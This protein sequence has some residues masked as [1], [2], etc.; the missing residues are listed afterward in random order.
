[1]ALVRRFPSWEIG[2]GGLGYFFGSRRGV[3]PP[4]CFNNAGE[5][6]SCVL[7]ATRREWNDQNASFRLDERIGAS[8]PILTALSH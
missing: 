5:K 8:H 7:A 4:N 3:A 6:A 1:M 2:G